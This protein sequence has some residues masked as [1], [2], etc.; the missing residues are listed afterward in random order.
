MAREPVADVLRV[1]RAARSCDISIT[2]RSSEVVSR[3][4][5]ARVPEEEQEQ[6]VDGDDPGR[7]QEHADGRRP[8]RV[9]H[10]SSAGAASAKTPTPALTA[11][12]QDSD[13]RRT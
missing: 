6:D 9:P 1:E 3:H 5:V 7:R 11:M 13:R 2:W 10:G 4:P 12:I 8:S